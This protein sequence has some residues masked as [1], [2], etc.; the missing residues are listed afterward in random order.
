MAEGTQVSRVRS[1][2]EDGGIASAKIPDGG[3]VIL[4]GD[5]VLNVLDAAGVCV[6]LWEQVREIRLAPTP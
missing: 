1:C 2:P 3:R 5:G 4:Y 6:S